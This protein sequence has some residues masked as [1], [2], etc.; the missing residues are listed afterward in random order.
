MSRSTRSGRQ[1]GLRRI[2]DAP[3]RERQSV[4]QAIL[5][6]ARWREYLNPEGADRPLKSPI[7]HATLVKARGWRKR[8]LVQKLRGTPSRG[9]PP[10]DPCNIRY[11]LDAANQQ[12][13]MAHNA[14]HYALVGADGYDAEHR[15][16][17]GRVQ[18][19]AKGIETIDEIRKATPWF[20]YAAGGRL[21]E[22]VNAWA[23]E[24]SEVMRERGGGNLRLAASLT[25][26]GAARGRCPA[27][28]RHHDHRGAGDHRTR[29]VDQERGR[30]AVDEVD[31]SCS[32]KPG[33]ARMSTALATGR[34][35]E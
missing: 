22:R 23:D 6:R 21:Q 3:A 24:I 1:I 15:F 29:A 7:P 32:A 12:V 27:S 28:A 20:Y 5:G 4:D 10:L 13:W 34:E 2:A 9:D 14:F 19:L 30:S 26:C 31:A 8:R 35:R 17:A 18:H 11:A 33:M 16:P 25:R